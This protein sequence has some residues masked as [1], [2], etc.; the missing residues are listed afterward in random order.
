MNVKSIIGGAVLA[1]VA[2]SAASPPA[3]ATN[4]LKHGSFEA[5][6]S[7]AG[8]V[9]FWTKSNTPTDAPASVID[10]NTAQAYP[11]GAFGEVVTPDNSVSLSPDAVGDKGAYFVGDLS[12]NETWSQLTYLSVG[13]YRIGFSYYLT[14]NGLA[15][16]NNSSLKGTIIGTPVAMTS[17]TNASQGQTWFN[18]SGVAQITQTGH[19]LTSLVF[20]S[21]GIPAK[22]IV[23]D[24]VYALST[25]DA[26]DVIIPPTPSMVPEPASWAMLISGFGLVG[27]AARRRRIAI[28]A[29]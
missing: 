17:V 10:Y 14:A 2:G 23:I 21:N 22:D 8:A 7:G 16:T 20:N 28:A 19:Y 12:N 27:A 4:R 29:A 1:I 15:N 13:N 5:G 26:P 3:A 6:A 18:V 11:L 25:V 9:P 24:R